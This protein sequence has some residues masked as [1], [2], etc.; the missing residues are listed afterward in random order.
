VFPTVFAV[1]GVTMWLRKRASRKALEG[2]HGT[3][4]LRPAE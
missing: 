2:K 4:Q 1:T 3:A